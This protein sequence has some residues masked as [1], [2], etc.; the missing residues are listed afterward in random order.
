MV[1]NSWSKSTFPDSNSTC[2]RLCEASGNALP[3][4]TT[5]FP[6]NVWG[7]FSQQWELLFRQVVRRTNLFLNFMQC[8][9]DTSN[10]IGGSL[11]RE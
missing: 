10:G 4:E 1:T 8:G 11:A 5:Q 2:L 3:S 6:A 7:L 9:H